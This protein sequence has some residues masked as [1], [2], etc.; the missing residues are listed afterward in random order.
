[1]STTWT[2]GEVKIA[3]PPKAPGNRAEAPQRG[4]Q[5]LQREAREPCTWLVSW[6]GG[7]EAW[8]EVRARGRTWRFPGHVCIAEAVLEVANGRRPAAGNP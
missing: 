8:I 3:R 5:L 6:R 4:V 7:A 2:L 1:V